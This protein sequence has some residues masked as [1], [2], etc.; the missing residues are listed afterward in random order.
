MTVD[1]KALKEA[2]EKA[3]GAEW[4]LV[5]ANEHHGPYLVGPA[6]DVADF[7]TMT[8][9]QSMSVRN[10]GD[11]KPV[12]FIDAVENA[13]FAALANPSTILSLIERCEELEGGLRAIAEGNLG[14]DPWQANYEKIRHVAAAYLTKSEAAS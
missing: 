4:D 11:S 14:D 1:M 9:P 7:Y 10:G 2:A 5:E 8:N 13:A 12:L 6:G 3:G